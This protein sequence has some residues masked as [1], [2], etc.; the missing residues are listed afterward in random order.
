MSAR[1]QD[2]LLRHGLLLMVATQFANVC[3]IL[4]HAVMGRALPGHYSELLTM[5]NV[6]LIISTPLEAV[7]TAA[8]HFAARAAQDGDRGAV[9][10]LVRAWSVRMLAVVIPL[11]LLAVAASRSIAGFFHF[12]G[13]APVVVTALTTIG[14]VL[15]P[16][17]AG[18]LQGLQSF[19][20][21]SL[22]IQGLSIVRMAAGAAAVW[23]LSRDAVGGLLGQT[24][25]VAASLALGGWGLTQVLRRDLAGT[26]GYLGRSFA[27]LTS[28]AALMMLDV[29]LV[30]HY[31]PGEA[32]AFSRAATVARSIIFLPMPIALAMFPK[33]VSD[34]GLN[35]A[36]RAIFWKALGIVGGLVGLGVAGC[37]VLPWLPLM[38]LYGRAN[39]TP[40]AVALVR[41]MVLAMTPL[42][43]AYLLMNFE[44]A[45]QR[46]RATPVLALAAVAYLGCAMIWHGRALHVAAA[47]ALAG[48]VATLGLAGCMPWRELIGGTRPDEGETRRP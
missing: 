31:V 26:S 12:A 5:L 36:S 11:A 44:M 43:L 14:M 15:I 40:E 47:L 38:V 20:W 28:F 21:M 32:E 25:G 23:W 2:G 45:Q 41:A 17:F 46:F 3:N 27:M 30:K 9:R 4:F 24:A 16:L 8:A 34:R 48:T 19:V 22:A 35:R 39:A 6:M 10:L 37:L 29:L 7:R 33:V 13:A 18:A 1:D 42:S